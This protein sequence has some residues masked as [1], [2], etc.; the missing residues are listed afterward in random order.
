MAFLSRDRRLVM[1]AAVEP[2][3]TPCVESTDVVEDEAA[4]SE[5]DRPSEESED[6][7]TM[8]GHGGRG[9]GVPTVLA[10]PPAGLGVSVATDTGATSVSFLTLGSKVDPCSSVGMRSRLEVSDRCPA[11]LSWDVMLGVSTLFCEGREGV[12]VDCANHFLVVGTAV[13]FLM[14]GTLSTDAGAV[15]VRGRPMSDTVLSTTSVAGTVSSTSKDS[16]LP[17]RRWRKVDTSTVAEAGSSW[18]VLMSTVEIFAVS[19]CSTTSF[20][21]S[22]TVFPASLKI[23]PRVPRPLVSKKATSSMLGSTIDSAI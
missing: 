18:A 10:A 23:P 19:A 16:V 20:T 11:R 4:A 21:P 6:W 7:V 22:L 12:R 2:G 17:G 8:E 15:S 13:G 3:P 5:D 1:R 9:D 14:I